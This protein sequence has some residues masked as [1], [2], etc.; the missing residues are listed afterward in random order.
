V[1]LRMTVGQQ[2]HNVEVWPRTK[3]EE[4]SVDCAGR[5]RRK[6]IAE[7]GEGV[8]IVDGGEKAEF[9]IGEEPELWEKSI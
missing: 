2:C 4:N 9:S 3:A 5:W 6:G 1:I 7:F 8:T